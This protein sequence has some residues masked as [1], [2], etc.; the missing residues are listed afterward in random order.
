MLNN[1]RARWAGVLMAGACVWA[2]ADAGAAPQLRDAAASAPPSVVRL[3]Q[4]NDAYRP[5]STDNDG[6]GGGYGGSYGGSDGS[7]GVSY[8]GSGTYRPPSNGAARGDDA[9]RP[10]GS[11]SYDSA[12][13]SGYGSGSAY[14]SGGRAGSGDAYRPPSSGGGYDQ[15]YDRGVPPSGGYGEPYSA[16]REE[17]YRGGGGSDYYDD[18][19]PRRRDGYDDRGDE[20]ST[21]SKNEIVEAGHGF[22]GSISKGLASVIEHAFK[23]AGR[24]NGYIL[25]EDAGGA[26]VAGLRY[27]EGRLHTKNAGSHK[28]FWQGPSIG[29]DFGG[30]G[31][32]TM[33][34]VYN[35]RDPSDVFHRFGGVEGTAYLVGG[36]S[37]QFLKY[38]D[39][40]MA[41]IRAGVGLRLGANIGYLKYTRSPTWNPF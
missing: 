18:R 4:A 10:Q 37:I 31:A 8:G 30:A 17:A 21:Y 13:G 6:G 36:V 23:K 2:S 14:N 19:G 22:F 35:L 29:Y 9:Y 20:R 12:G 33:V 7:Y 24:P 38:G 3:A 28:V 32:K 27:G 41:P 11:G 34:L 15:G 39:V 1:V 25:G 26:F 40:T 5:P 16:P